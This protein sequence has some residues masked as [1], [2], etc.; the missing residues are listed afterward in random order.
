MADTSSSTLQGFC[1][2]PQSQ[3]HNKQGYHQ[4]ISNYTSF[5]DNQNALISALLL[6]GYKGTDQ[7]LDT[8]QQ[9]TNNFIK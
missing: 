6:K 8:L 4:T 9:S 1:L 5:L 3:T 7:I 2:P